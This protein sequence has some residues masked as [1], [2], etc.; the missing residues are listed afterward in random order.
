MPEGL[1]A[2]EVSRDIQEHR[3]AT[4]EEHEEHRNRRIMII[5]AVL[6]SLVAVLAAWSGFAAAKWSTESSLRLSRASAA[7]VEANAAGLRALNSV[8]FDV[9]AFNAWFTAYVANDRSAMAVAA[10]RFTPN[11]HRAFNAWLATHPATN[12]G[13]PPG[14]TYMPQYRQPEKAK[15]QSLNALA[16]TDY[17]KGVAAGANSDGYVLTTVYLATVLFLAG[18]GSHF[19]LRGVRYALAS[20]GGAILLV[21]VFRLVTAA[22]PP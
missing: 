10:R 2:G 5:E 17:A 1:S 16:S 6:L 13:A 9:T 8:N 12:P 20:V 4:E 11:F 19:E 15:A 21:A 18:I 7:R 3:E 14:P 22:K